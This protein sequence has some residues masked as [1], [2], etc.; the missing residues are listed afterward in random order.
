M[1]VF[2]SAEQIVE[3]RFWND[4]NKWRNSTASIFTKI[5]CSSKN[6]YTLNLFSDKE[7]ILQL[8][9][10]IRVFLVTDCTL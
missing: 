5:I 9:I 10:W 3:G 6:G 1:Y 8:W 7:R 4:N 2:G